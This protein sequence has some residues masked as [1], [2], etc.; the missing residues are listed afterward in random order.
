MI[1]AATHDLGQLLVGE[2]RIHRNAFLFGHRLAPDA[3]IG[4]NREILLA[5]HLPVIHPRCRGAG[6]GA[7]AGLAF[8]RLQRVRRHARASGDRDA[9]D[10]IRIRPGGDEPALDAHDAVR[11]AEAVQFVLRRLRV[12]RRGRE[13]VHG[14]GQR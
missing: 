5:Q 14:H 8:R 2:Y 11:R 12:E 6:L 7:R 13:E 9:Q 1:D 10:P 3:Q 4:V